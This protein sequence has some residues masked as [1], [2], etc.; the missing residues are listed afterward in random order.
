MKTLNVDVAVIGAGSAGLPAY[1]AAKAEGA[2]AVLIE[3]G[4]YGTTCARVGCMPSKLLI[5]AADAAHHASSTAPFGVYVDGNVRIDGRDVMRR[6]R[7]ER[8][9]FVGFVVEGVEQMPAEDRLRGDAQFVD[10][11][12]LQVG[13]DTRVRA[14]S[15]V[16][17][18][19]S[20][21]VVPAMYRTLGDRVVV[22]DDVFEWQDLPRKVAV[23]GAGVIGLELGQ[24][25]SRLGVAVTLL[26]GARGHVGP[27]SDPDI[28]A[29][30]RGVFEQAFRFES[31]A[32]VEAATRVGDTVQLRYR[33][34]DGDVVDDTF[35]YL[36][37]AAGRRPNVGRLALHNT[38]LALDGDG[39][40]VYDP[41]TLQAGGQP[42][43]IAGD[44]NGVLPLLHEAADEGRMAGLNAARFPAVQPLVRR[45]PISVVFTDPGIAMVGA[46]HADLAPDAYVVGEV[47]FEDQG[48]SRVMLRNRGLMHVYADRAT[49]RFVGA[50]WIG[51]DAE[52][53]AHLLAW[54]LQMKLT[55]DAMLAMPFYHP[56]VEEGVRTA[57][58][59]AAA[60][61]A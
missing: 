3:G 37:I 38:S 8:D 54:A 41:L 25:L 47:S 36:L 50:E 17:A 57:L 53:I 60:R 4:P 7:S 42:V 49:R 44:A 40:P 1:R 18:T 58:R 56:V 16:I 27:L 22:N 31:R 6:V 43:F 28:A 5:A 30:A 45:A 10:D 33:R 52:H 19:G 59:S 12:L 2:R 26:G 51:P 29:Y 14:R 23:I 11:G 21:P 35:D 48:R 15:I 39:V 20:T 24:A 61:L 32:H 55:V 46:R 9:R 13:D 34:A